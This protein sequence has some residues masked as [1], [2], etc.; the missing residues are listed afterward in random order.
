[1]NRSILRISMS[2]VAAGIL[3][4]GFAFVPSFVQLPAMAESASA[5]DEAILLENGKLV[6]ENRETALKIL[7]KMG[8]DAN[9]GTEAEKSLIAS[10]EGKSTPAEKNRVL[11]LKN[12]LTFK[13]I[14]AKAGAAPIDT[15][16]ST[17]GT[18]VDQNQATLLQ[19]RAVL[20][21]AAEKLGIDLG[22]PAPLAEGS[23]AVQNNA[24]LKAN[25]A[26]LAKFVAK[27]GS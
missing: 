27:L 2:L 16:P 11:F 22:T 14:A 8:G 6:Q 26:A 23:K 13:A 7:A 19:N 9:F 25:K 10:F 5:G 20:K 24:L 15:P 4:T 1:M 12:Q 21:S 17:E 18:I 3:S